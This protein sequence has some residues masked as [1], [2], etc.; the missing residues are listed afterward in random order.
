MS[1]I[2]DQFVRTF[3]VND[4]ILIAGNVERRRGH[5]RALERRRQ[6]P[7]AVNVAVPVETAAEA[8]AG[9]LACKEVDVGLGEPAR[10]ALGD[11]LRT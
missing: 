2:L 10:Q 5:W 11:T 1:K 9:E 7:V 4:K 3:E 6:F 8:G